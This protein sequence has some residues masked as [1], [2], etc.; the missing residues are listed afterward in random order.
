MLKNLSRLVLI[1]FS[2]LVISAQANTN[3]AILVDGKSQY[4][5]QIIELYKTEVTELMEGEFEIEFTT[6]IPANGGW[7]FK[8]IQSKYFGLQNSNNVDMVLTLGLVASLVAAYDTAPKKPTFAPYVIDANFPGLPRDGL[9]SGINNLS[10]L[11]EEIALQS[12]LEQFKSITG[13]THM[14]ILLDESIFNAIQDLPLRVEELTEQM[15][16]KASF[17]LQNKPNQNL[18]TAI[19]DDADAVIVTALPRLNNQALQAL[20]DGLNERKI[21]SYSV[22]RPELVEQ[23]VLM[24]TDSEGDD[25]RRARRTALNIQATLLGDEPAYFPVLFTPKEKL[26][27]NMETARKIDFYPRFD[28]LSQAILLNEQP[29]GEDPPLSLQDVAHEAIKANLSVIASRLGV[30]SGQQDVNITRS[31][32]FPQLSVGAVSSRRDDGSLTVE[33]GGAAEGTTSARLSL[34]QVIYSEATRSAYDI[35][36]LQQLSLEAQHRALELDIVQQATVAFL[37]V[38]RAQTQVKINQNQLNLS[39][40]NLSLAKNRQQ[41]GSANAA[42]VYRFESQ[43]ATDRQTLLQSQASLRSA[44]DALNNLLHRPIGVVFKTIPATLEHDEVLFNGSDLEQLI[45]NER[46][47]LLFQDLYIKLGQ[48]MS[49]EVAQQ[50]ALIAAARRQLTAS[51]RSYYVPDLTLEG[52]T[53]RIIDES[54][55]QNGTSL[56]DENDWEISLNLSLP[57]YQGGQRK[58]NV[59]KADYQLNQTKILRE[60]ALRQVE[61]NVRQFF[62]EINASYPSIELSEQAAMS[63]SQNYE[64]I[65]DNYSQGVVSI[66]DLIDAQNAALTAEQNSSNAVYDFLIDLMNLQRSIGVFD[67][68]LDEPSRQQ[69]IELIKNYVE[70][71]GQQ[72]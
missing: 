2:I 40:V 36:K 20:I 53:S 14:V 13:F 30:L 1:L 26:V 42:D 17:V 57:L 34:S 39:L 58:A 68:F 31:A 32:L 22:V 63:A 52:N 24:A 29:V 66:A 9:S 15:G 43:I 6:H 47:L 67:Y 45:D 4:Y 35:Q 59:L 44:S 33:S 7:T 10:Y 8:N 64:L 3:I 48:Q 5:D 56:E 38:L 18:L 16:G 49:P 25:Q 50:D 70:S 37:N 28:V 71:G 54:G 61:Q 21:P 65:Q 60:Q 27:I 62:H 55:R 69:R 41:V 51:K 23:G 46:D 12:D 72:Q 19:P 11:A